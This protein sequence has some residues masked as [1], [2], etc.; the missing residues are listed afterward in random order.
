MS[1]PSFSSFQGIQ[2]IS[3]SGEDSKQKLIKEKSSSHERKKKSKKKKLENLIL[4]NYLEEEVVVDEEQ[5]YY[6]DTKGNRIDTKGNRISHA[7]P[8]LGCGIDS[9]SRPRDYYID[10]QGDWKNLK[11]INLNQPIPLYKP[12][13]PWRYF[14]K[15]THIQRYKNYWVVN[16]ETLSKRMPYSELNLF[17][18]HL[19]RL[20]GHREL[21]ASKPTDY[22]KLPGEEFEEMQE[23]LIDYK[24]NI[25]IDY[26]S[27]I[28]GSTEFQQKSIQADR[29][30]QKNPSCVENWINFINLQDE[31]KAGLVSVP[32]SLK[33]V[34]QSKKM[35]IVEK[36][37]DQIPDAEE[38]QSIYLDLK[39]VEL[40]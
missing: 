5:Y 3:G 15:N 39:S 32:T 11:T 13:K 24:S 16:S 22:I 27:N 29:L 40:E 36:A 4:N 37:M 12:P 9:L 34:I 25:S 26:K 1:F 35:A 10:I 17:K 23:D 21:E 2:S 38:L 6:Q 28:P 30:I 33:N 8:D 18:N 19:V 31:L 14:G 20:T 7:P